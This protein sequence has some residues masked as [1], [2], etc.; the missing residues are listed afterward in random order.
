M[1]ASFSERSKT[2]AHHNRNIVVD[3][4]ARKV[5][6]E[7]Q[8]IGEFY[9]GTRRDMMTCNFFDVGIDGKFERVVVWMAGASPLG[10][11]KN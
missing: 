5:S 8:Y 11:G 6:T 7:Q 4:V 2:M 10:N 1:L 3:E 9:D